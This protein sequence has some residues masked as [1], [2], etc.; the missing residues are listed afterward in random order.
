VSETP[1]QPVRLTSLTFSLQ[2]ILMP[3]L[4]A[5]K[6]QINPRPSAQFK[7]AAG[8]FIRPAPRKTALK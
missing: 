8:N 6:C 1:G 2:A 4:I 7:S 3:E 5:G